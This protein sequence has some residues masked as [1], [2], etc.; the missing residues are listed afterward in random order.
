MIFRQIKPVPLENLKLCFHDL[1]DT[2]NL[3]NLFEEFSLQA[4]NKGLTFK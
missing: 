2:S 4:I 1:S 3:L